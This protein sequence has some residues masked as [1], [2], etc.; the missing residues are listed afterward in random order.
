MRKQRSIGGKQDADR[1]NDILAYIDLS[2]AKA[3]AVI[4]ELFARSRT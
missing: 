1:L 3:I 4:E 2:K